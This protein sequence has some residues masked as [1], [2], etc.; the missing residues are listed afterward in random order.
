MHINCYFN[1]T[2]RNVLPQ[3]GRDFGFNM[4]IPAYFGKIPFKQSPTWISK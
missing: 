4:Q 3:V 2:L 1:I